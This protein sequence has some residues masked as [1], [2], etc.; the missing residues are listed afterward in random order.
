MNMR[1][2]LSFVGY[3]IL[4]HFFVLSSTSGEIHFDPLEM[5]INSVDLH[6]KTPVTFKKLIF[7]RFKKA[8]YIDLVQI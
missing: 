8:G 4:I 3:Y 2:Y 7:I 5:V 1:T 6:L